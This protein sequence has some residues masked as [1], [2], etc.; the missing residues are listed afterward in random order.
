[1]QFGSIGATHSV[2]LNMTRYKAASIH[3]L[4][5]A[6]VGAA[7]FLFMVMVWYPGPFFKA[8]GG[9]G[10]VLLLLG[11]DICIGPL[12]TLVAFN[13]AK[14]SLK[15]DLTVIAL[16]QLGALIYGLSVVFEARVVYSAFVID[17]FEMIRA[18]EID[19]VDLKDAKVERFKSLPLLRPQTIGVNRPTDQKER[20]KALDLALQG[21]DLHLRP[22]YYVDYD[23]AQKDAVKQKIMPMSRLKDLNPASTGDIESAIKATGKAEADLGFLPMRGREKDLSV[24]IDRATGDVL[25]YWTY[26][27]WQS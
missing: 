16:L 22:E 4:L 17:R 23:Q 21:K 24:I 2:R 26:R 11:V 10:L 7:A 1:M 9:E 12:L 27:P 6:C 18:A 25:D 5:S 20:N 19:P 8:A 15:M 13:T 3:L 14:K